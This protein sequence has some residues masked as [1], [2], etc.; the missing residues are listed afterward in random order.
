MAS[1]VIQGGCLCGAIRYEA[2]GT[3]Y[4]VTHCHCMDCRRS[5]AA[6]FVTWAT[7]RRS[8][9]RF[10]QGEPGVLP[11]AGRVRCF[12]V[13]CGTPL[14]F[15]ASPQ[16]EEVDVTVCSFDDPGR[17]QPADHTW[18]EDRLSWIPAPE[19]LPEHQRS[20]AD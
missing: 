16:A 1:D 12:C 11:W 13:S 5:S 3:P 6:A 10:T 7:F 2:A 4:H 19:G 18:V 14:T 17:L 9:F 20:R 8:G 15:M